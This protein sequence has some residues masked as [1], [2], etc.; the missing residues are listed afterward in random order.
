MLRDQFAGVP[1][2]DVAIA[3]ARGERGAAGGEGD[4]L[5]AEDAF[6]QGGDDFALREIPHMQRAVAARRREPAIVARET[7]RTDEPLMPL[8]LARQLLLRQIPY[9]DE[10]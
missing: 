10:A 8:Q 5:K 3:A 6:L 7:E 1:E 2:R 4:G 9:P